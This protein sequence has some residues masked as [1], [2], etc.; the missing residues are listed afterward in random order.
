MIF[1]DRDW[2]LNAVNG[3]AVMSRSPYDSQP[4]RPNPNKKAMALPGYDVLNNL[5]HIASDIYIT[6]G[7]LSSFKRRDLTKFAL[8][9]LI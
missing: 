2:G 8:M 6:T 4:H 9:Y 7:Q 1:H 5:R 3:S